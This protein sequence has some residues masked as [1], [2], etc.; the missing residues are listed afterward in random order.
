MEG[1]VVY[2]VS[3]A[4]VRRGG[5]TK[6]GVVWLSSFLLQAVLGVMMLS[7]GI[8]NTKEVKTYRRATTIGHLGVLAIIAVVMFHN[9]NIINSVTAGLAVLIAAI[10]TVVSMAIAQ[11][12]FWIMCPN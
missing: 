10:V 6:T 4:H 9:F 5:K 7:K 3:R 2:K 12:V 1:S 11:K 8:G